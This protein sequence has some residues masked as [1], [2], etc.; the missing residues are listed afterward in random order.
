[1]TEAPTLPAA[2]HPADQ[3]SPTPPG[4]IDERSPMNDLLTNPR[5]PVLDKVLELA[6]YLAQHAHES[7]ELN[8]LPDHVAEAMRNTGVMRMLQPKEFGGMEA[9]PSDFMRAVLNIGIHD[10]SAGW[11]AGV[12]GVHPHE[13]AQ[14]SLRS[15]QEL[16]GEDP[17]TWIASPYAPMG[18]AVP[19]EGGYLFNGRWP[20]SS[21]TDHCSW[22]TIGGLIV[23]EQGNVIDPEPR[24]FLLP[25]ADYEVD[26]DSW[27]VFGLRG[28]GSKD[29]IVKDAF[30]PE[31]RTIRTDPVTDG[32]AN[33]VPE[34][35]TTLYRM[36]R[37]IIFSGAIT[38]ATLALAYGTLAHLVNWIDTRE[39][40]FG[41]ASTDPF[42][43]EALGSAAA[44]IDACLVQYFADI[45]R[46]YDI[47]DSGRALTFGQRADIRRNQVRASQR[48]VE[49]ADHV[50]RLSGGSQLKKSNPAQR[51]WRDAKAAL[52]HVQ[53]LQGKMMQAWGLHR[54]GH[55]VPRTV[56]I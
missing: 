25:R 17:D 4:P 32:T 53:N 3:P 20:F 15:Q 5:T 42:Q 41:K 29:L 34:R 50:F 55:P 47:V 6:D 23:D 44:D 24:H 33:E 7:E 43:L 35:D 21:G 2:A 12:V 22:V 11:V 51:H 9:H 27:D 46:A 40:R 45:D 30:V 37:N 36:P 18:R 19:V 38:G 49:A 1:M 26:Q 28:T 39:S 48:A 16:W 56:K 8:R 14:G 52:H 13:L 31:Y 10:G 54:F